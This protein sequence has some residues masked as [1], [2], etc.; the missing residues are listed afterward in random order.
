MCYERYFFF[1]CVYTMSILYPIP[2]LLENAFQ[3]RYSTSCEDWHFTHMWAA[4][5]WPHNFN[6]LEVWATF[7]QHV[8]SQRWTY[9]R[10]QCCQFLLIVHSWLSILDCASGFL[11]HLSCVYTMS[12]LYPI[13]ALL[14]NAFQPSYSTSCEDWHFTHMWAALAWPHNFNK[15][16][17]WSHK[18][19]LTKYV[20]LFFFVFF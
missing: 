20:F 10:N 19:C 15:L 18:A 17:V 9:V 14:E 7:R 12:I 4:L 5:A 6:K 3:P 8:N 2:A 11:W 16:E 13:P 1:S